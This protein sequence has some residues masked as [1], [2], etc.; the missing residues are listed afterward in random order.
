MGTRVGKKDTFLFLFFSVD[1]SI[2]C[3]YTHLNL[4]LDGFALNT[5]NTFI[6]S[7]LSHGFSSFIFSIGLKL[8]YH[9]TLDSSSIAE[10]GDPWWA[11]LP[12]DPSAPHLPWPGSDTG[13]ESHPAVSPC[14][15]GLGSTPLGDGILCSWVQ[16]CPRPCYTCL[17]QGG[18][19]LGFPS[20]VLCTPVGL[21]LWL[22]RNP[23]LSTSTWAFLVGCLVFP[24][25]CGPAL[26]SPC[27]SLT[28]RSVLLCPLPLCLLSRVLVLRYGHPGTEDW[29]D[30]TEWYDSS[31]PP[32]FSSSWEDGTYTGT[33]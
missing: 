27:L 9:S 8:V 4:F 22:S 18:M 3:C 15:H 29:N 17:A 24:S 28:L 13:S 25:P 33:V 32:K 21:S 26:P 10:T 19:K 14:S 6:G 16:V 5:L 31:Y 23:V 7:V 1:K 11:Q 20:A 30:H 2:N 12:T